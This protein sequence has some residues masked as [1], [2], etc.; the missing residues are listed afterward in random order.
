MDRTFDAHIIATSRAGNYGRAGESYEVMDFKI[1]RFDDGLLEGRLHYERGSNQGGGYNEAHRKSLFRARSDCASGAV[2]MLLDYTMGLKSDIPATE[3]RAAA[4]DC[5]YK[6]EDRVESDIPGSI[7][8]AC[9]IVDGSPSFSAHNSERDGW[10]DLWDNFCREFWEREVG[11]PVPEVKDNYAELVG[12][13]FDAATENGKSEEC[14]VVQ[15][16]LPK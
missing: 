7:W 9:S 12:R 6:A 16:G 10:I 1:A 14:F 15:V 8:I 4:M 13:Y 5:Q 3:I 11:E 2:A